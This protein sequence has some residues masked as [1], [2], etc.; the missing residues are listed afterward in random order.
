MS[1]RISFPDSLDEITPQWLTLAL[2]PRHPHARVSACTV[3]RV[4]GG[5]ATKA[6]LLLEYEGCAE[7]GSEGLPPT[8][9]VKAGWGA[10]TD[11]F[12]SMCA[13]EA[14][15]FRDL[16]PNL[17]INAP[18]C[19]AEV[20][21]AGNSN[22]VMLLED[23]LARGATFGNQSTPLQPEQMLQVLAQQAG[24]HSAY[25]RDERLKSIPWLKPGGMIKETNVIETY[26]GFWDETCVLPRFDKVPAALRDRPRMREALLRMQDNNL[27]DACCIVHGDPHQANLFFDA[28]GSPGYLDWAT[29]M[30]CHW[31]FDV[32]YLIIGSQS[33]EHRRR[34][35]REQLRFYLD[36][37]ASHGVDVPTFDSAWLAYRQNAMWMFLTALCPT[38]MHPEDVCI[39]NTERACAAIGDLETVA[40][41]LA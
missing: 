34:H 37:L 10:H 27:R 23:L 31:A 28:D 40:S 4:I 13:I 41:L 17:P 22:G 11:L 3:D 25:W 15:F 19:Y 6:R 35:E 39:L 32:A 21:Q 24:Y 8:L 5:M 7:E 12:Q 30:I 9:W 29:V 2:A 26:L 14:L 20:V 16:A 33:V 18:R 38:A 1:E 36:Q